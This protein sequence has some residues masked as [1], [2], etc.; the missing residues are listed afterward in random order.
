MGKQST[1][2]AKLAEL[3]QRV[4]ELY[5]Q[6]KFAVALP[7]AREAAQLAE[8]ELGPEHPDL[9][10]S[11]N[12]LGALLRAMGEYA[13]ALPYYEQGLAMRRQL[14]PEQRHPD[15]H[16]ELAQSLN[17]LGALLQA[18]GEHAQALPYY[19]QSLAMRLRLYP[20]QRYP[21]GH[22]A[23]GLRH[24][25]RSLAFGAAILSQ[26]RPG[27]SAPSLRKPAACRQG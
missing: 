9:A 6:G 3:N 23:R 24:G 25:R 15:G 11:L 8:R 12:D 18:M 1:G 22:P 14:Y 17:N 13:R 20:E 16:P 19:E 27:L 4:E 21:D 26:P 5:Q 7:V 2:S 10:R